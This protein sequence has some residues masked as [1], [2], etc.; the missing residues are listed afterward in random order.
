MALPTLKLSSTAT[1]SP[2]SHK[3]TQVKIG[4]FPNISLA[5]ARA[6]LQTFIEGTYE[7]YRYEAECKVWLKKWADYLDTLK[8]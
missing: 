8:K 1:P 6:E 3:F 5:Q 4:H 7:L 2:L